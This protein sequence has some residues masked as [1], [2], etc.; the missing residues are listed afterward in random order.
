ML[1]R[2]CASGLLS[3]L[4][5]SGPGLASGVYEG[6]DAGTTGGWEPNTSKTAIEVHAE[7]G[8]NNSGYLRSYE[9]DD[10]F[11]IVGALQRNEPYVGD[12]AAHGYTYVEVALQFIEGSFINAL[13]RVRYSSGAYNGWHRRLTQDFTPGVWHRT[14]ILFDPTWSDAQ[15]VEAG[16]VQ[17][18]NSPSFQQTMTNV[19]TTEIRLHGA[20]DLV[21][22]LDDFR[23]GGRV[24]TPVA[25]M[26]WGQVK[27]F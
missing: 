8:M 16:W 4:V 27:S 21:V 13:F 9:V 2:I 23:L 6:W 3:V 19:Y 22:G 12:F 20:G 10:G 18:S 11:N 25:P 17:E 7:G 1:G 5:A 15:A 26:S 24:M 14:R